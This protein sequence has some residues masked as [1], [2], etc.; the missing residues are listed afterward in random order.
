MGRPKHAVAR[1]DNRS[2]KIGYLRVKGAAKYLGTTEKVVR[3][4]I[5]RGHLKP[6]RLAGR[7]YLSRDDID[8]A[9]RESEVPSGYF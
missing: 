8:R 7:L 5:D 1:E 3:H 6:Y 4:L 9:L 2:L